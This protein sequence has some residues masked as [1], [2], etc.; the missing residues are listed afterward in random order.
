MR[1]VAECGRKLMNWCGVVV[2][3][4]SVCVR[5]VLGYPVEVLCCR[6]Y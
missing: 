3:F 1:L 5:G 6:G 2:L 4:V